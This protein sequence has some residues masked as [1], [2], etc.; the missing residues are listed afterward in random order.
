MLRV[1]IV[2]S[3]AQSRKLSVLEEVLSWLLVLSVQLF[4]LCVRSSNRRC[5][6]IASIAASFRHDLGPKREENCASRSE[7]RPIRGSNRSRP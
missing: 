2:C 1:I 4:A 7:E 5:N 3:M 6:Q